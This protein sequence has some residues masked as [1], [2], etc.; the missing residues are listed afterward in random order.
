[1]HNI[2]H[3]VNVATLI[4]LQRRLSFLHDRFCG[5]LIFDTAS[6]QTALTY[7]N[8]M[9]V[10]AAGLGAQQTYYDLHYRLFCKRAK[11]QPCR[12]A[13]IKGCHNPTPCRIRQCTALSIDAVSTSDISGPSETQSIMA[14]VMVDI[15]TKIGHEQTHQPV[16]VTDVCVT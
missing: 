8:R 1:M 5:S 15:N 14:L 6:T 7:L 16:Y 4:C 2:L 13:A 3:A 9:Q 10:V 12:Q 11:V